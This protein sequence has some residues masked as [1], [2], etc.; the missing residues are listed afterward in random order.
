MSHAFLKALS[1]GVLLSPINFTASAQVARSSITG[2]VTDVQG[3]R[4]PSTQVIATEISTGLQRTTQTSAQGIYT[5]PDLPVG[6]F[7]VE[8]S[9][10]GFANVTVKDVKQVVGQT[11]T[12]DAAL[13]VVGKTEQATI[14]ESTVQLDKV[15]ATIG[16]PIELKQVDALPINGRNWATLT[17]LVPGATDAG[18]GDQRT[19]RFVGHG[20]DDNNLT[21]D[22]VDATAV[23]NQEQREYVRLT[24]PLDSIEEFDV[25]SQ[26]FGADVEGGTAGAQ[27]SVVSPSGTNTFHGSTFDFFRNSDIEARSP[28]DGNSPNPFL[29]NQF[30][31][32]VGGPILKNKFFFYANY[33][34]LRQ[35]LDGTQIGLV[36]SPSLIARASA[37]S[38]ALIP[39][40]KAYPAGTSPTSKTD[41]WNY[42]ANGRSIDNEDSGMIRLDY[43]FSNKTTAFVRY[44]SEEAIATTPTGNLTALT[45]F[46]TKFNNGVFELLDVF[47]PTVV[48]EF[49]FG[50]NQDQ[51]HTG[52]VAPLPYT[53]SVSGLSSLAGN[54]TSDNPSKLISFANDISWSRGGHT[55]KF[56]FEAKGYFIN[57]GSSSSGTLSYSSTGAFLLNQMNNA[58]YKSLLP[59][60]RQRKTEYFAYAEDEWKVSK[61]LT[62]NAGVRY[63]I[64]NALSAL[65]NNAVPFDFNTCGG[66]CP[67]TYS[68]FNPRYHDVDPRVGVEWAHGGTVVRAGAGLYHTDG[69]VDDQNLPIS[70]TVASYSFNGANPIFRGLSYP[71]DPYLA[72][73]QNGGLGV[74]SPR[75]LDR[76]R[77][78]MYVAAWTLSLQET[79]PY[80]L[81]GTLSYVGN[82]GTN[83]LTT[84]YTNLADPVTGKV[85]DPQFGA[86]TWRGDV[87]NSTFH[88]LQ[89]NV[90]R[91]FSNGFLVT[92][93]YMWSHSIN[94]GSIGGGDS[95]VPQNSFCRSCDKGNSDFD[96]RHLFNISTVYQLPFGAGKRFLSSPGPWRSVLSNF[97]VSAIGTTQSGLPANITIDRINSTV[98]GNLRLAVRRVP[99]SCLASP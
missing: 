95:D 40:L 22:G 90:R 92:S 57:Q 51:Y 6:V 55:L 53:V 46:D 52:T 93:N 62:I 94:D 31:G 85:P 7:R 82:K 79:L 39:L 54:T 19:I 65:G 98:P 56:G 63:N 71:L 44:N 86:V 33:E 69:Q 26:T 50:F 35:R 78:D 41:V 91:A 28:F 68:Y 10:A 83:V 97:E 36:P 18:A 12:L 75:A 87:G 42:H 60:V 89:F 38:P 72:Y 70:N 13:E 37:T 25:K 58:T 9:K 67:R 77:K 27:V 84:T 45:K 59:L 47:T 73:A 15:D 16:A 4:V 30:G 1:F 80:K 11:R 21:L 88:A 17:T 96:I 43:R 2:T 24:I 48:N 74:I 8:F 61:S 49:K 32:S 20:L 66:Y 3:A 29:L 14:T 76:N 23:Y 81:L 64:F 5:M 34:G 99:T